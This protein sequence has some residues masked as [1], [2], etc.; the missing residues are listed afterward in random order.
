MD[1]SITEQDRKIGRIVAVSGARVVA[2]LDEPVATPDDPAAATYEL[3]MGGIVKIRMPDS[4]VFGMIGGL[5]IPLPSDDDEI[6]E[7]RFVELDLLGECQDLGSEGMSAFRRGVSELPS[8]SQ[9]VY[10]AHQDDL[11][12]VY[13]ATN[14]ESVRIGTIHQDRSLPAFAVTDELLGKHFAVLG[15]TGSGKSCAVA[16]ILR[17]ILGKYPNGHVVLLDVHNEYSHSFGQRAE[18]LHPGTLE[19]PYWL[20]NFEELEQ[21]VLGHEKD[22]R[23]T[24]SAILSEVVL[25]AKHQYAADDPQRDKITVDTPVPYRIGDAARRVDDAVGRLDKTRETSPYLR[26]KE[27]FSMLQTDPRYSFM[28]P[29]LSIED[30]MALILARIFR[31]PVDGKPITI[32]DLSGVPSEILNVVVSVLARLTFEFAVWSDRGMPVLLVCE[33][34]HRY[35]PREIGLG[36]EPTKR[37]LARIA[38]EG[39]KYGVSLCVVS[40]RPSE[41]A[42]DI[43]SQCNT[44]LALRM[45]NQKDQEFVEAMLSESSVGLL[46]CLPSLGNAEAIAIGE[47]VSVP[48][49]LRFNELSEEHRPRSGTASFSDAWASD[50]DDP[51]F[52]GRVLERWRSQHRDE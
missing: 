51:D 41:L 15:T 6:D 40:Q 38:K 12:R 29:G 7:M 9:E 52:L 5:T 43:L 4:I 3:Q 26:L 27:R 42:V 1:G 48:V 23:E 25:Y 36:F 19:V 8:L 13:A 24:M 16:V 32:V 35:A 14:P 49:R 30:R 39:R 11:A 17:A 37:A 34:A 45:S 50:I 2:L 31:I 20:L 28:F 47:G 22:D 18:C 46:D 44:I 10:R 21:V 33:E